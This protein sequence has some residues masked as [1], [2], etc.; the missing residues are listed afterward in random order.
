MTNMVKKKKK[1]KTWHKCAIAPKNKH[2]EITMSSPKLEE[3][4][5]KIQCY[6]MITC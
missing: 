4:N 6:K 1:K 2:F 3:K 5:L